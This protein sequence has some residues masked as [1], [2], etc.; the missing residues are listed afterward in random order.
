MSP[1]LL[2]H[3]AQDCGAGPESLG[4]CPSD[5]MMLC[6]QQVSAWRWGDCPLSHVPS[7]SCQL[8]WNCSSALGRDVLT[9][10]SGA[11][12]TSKGYYSAEGKWPKF[13]RTCLS[14]IS[15]YFFWLLLGIWSSWARDQRPATVE[16]YATTVATPGPLTQ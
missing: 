2:A 4:L 15:F 9:V 8:P 7:L 11:G 6:P 10:N 1:D 3:P 16:T 12:I 13:L 14:Q 5:R